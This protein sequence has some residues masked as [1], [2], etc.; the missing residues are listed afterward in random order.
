MPPP[1]ECGAGRETEGWAGSGRPQP[2]AFRAVGPARRRAGGAGAPR[3]PASVGHA[4]P[5]KLVFREPRLG[6]EEVRAEPLL[7]ARGLPGLGDRR[8]AAKLGA[9]RC[10]EPG[11]WKGRGSLPGPP[12]SESLELQTSSLPWRRVAFTSQYWSL[13]SNS[14]SS[15]HPFL[16]NT[17]NLARASFCSGCVCVIVWQGEPQ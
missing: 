7:A 8:W 2:I 17:K 3:P 9:P 16:T 5:A 4:P 1:P 6:G 10:R 13:T 15:G 14:T 12:F 11:V